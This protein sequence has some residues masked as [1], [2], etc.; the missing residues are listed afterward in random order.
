MVDESD[1][2]HV[3]DFILKTEYKTKSLIQIL[4]KKSSQGLKL[5]SI[6]SEYG[7]KWE[8]TGDLSL[9]FNPEKVKKVAAVKAM[10]AKVAQKAKILDKVVAMIDKLKNEQDIPK[11]QDELAKYSQIIEKEA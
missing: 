5:T 8:I 2:G 3:E 6:K 4:A 9:Y 1:R 7:D 10:R 11:V